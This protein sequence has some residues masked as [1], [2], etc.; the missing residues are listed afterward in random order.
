MQQRSGDPLA[1]ARALAQRIAAN[2][3]RA[4]RGLKQAIDRVP[5]GEE[6]FDAAFG[7]AELAE[8]LAAFRERRPPVFR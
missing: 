7:G 8:G 2:A 3:P 5:H 1:Q 6:R 4:V